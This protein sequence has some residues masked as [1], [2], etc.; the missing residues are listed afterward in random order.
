M[1][2]QVE[3]KDARLGKKKVDLEDRE[4]A[5]EGQIGESAYLV[6]SVLAIKV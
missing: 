3:G 1:W 5:L 6:P 2:L 4:E